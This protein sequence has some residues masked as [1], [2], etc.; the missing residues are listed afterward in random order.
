MKRYHLI[1][2]TLACAGFATAAA[3]DCAA[4]IDALA[5]GGGKDATLAPLGDTATP[6]TGGTMAKE[7]GEAAKGAGKDGSLAPMGANPDLA[8]SGQDAQ[9]QSE[10]GETAA[11][12]AAGA[13]GSDTRQS[14][15][16]EARA[17]LAKGDEA[18]CMA[19]VE[20]A[21]GM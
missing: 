14:A 17:A 13:S 4:E 21:K 8:T 12:Q 15:L 2:A 11:A 19:A 18:G 16:D 7:S 3:A 5:M 1:A 9:A 6:Q 10:G 20:K